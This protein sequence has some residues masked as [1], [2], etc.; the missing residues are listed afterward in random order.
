MSFLFFIA[1]FQLSFGQLNIELNGKSLLKKKNGSTADNPTSSQERVEANRSKT[2]QPQQRKVEAET[3]VA[4]PVGEIIYTVKECKNF[5]EAEKFKITEVKDGDS[6]WMYLRFPSALIN[7]IP[8][9]EHA[10]TDEDGFDLHSLRV[11][12]GPQ[13]AKEIWNIWAFYFKKRELNTSELKINLAPGVPG[14]NKSANSFLQT[15]GRGRPGIWKNAMLVYVKY[16]EYLAIG[17]ITCNVENGL[18]KYKKMA[19]DLYEKVNV[20][21]AEENK[22][23]E[24]KGFN[25]AQIR[26]FCVNKIKEKGITITKFYFTYDNW[27]T[28]SNG[29]NQKIAREMTAVFTYKIKDECFFGTI[30]L[31]Q[32]YSALTVQ[33]GENEIKMQPGFP[34]LCK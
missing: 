15:V 19:T 2:D 3:N 31:R 34:Y 25:D 7:Y 17:P 8:A 22:L 20:G 6:L 21:T 1:T 10:G 27:A 18:A 33:Y 29:N 32:P 12:M 24:A 26:Q 9:D 28:V 4:P 13:D 5:E 11:G 16:E 30:E 23:P 14:R